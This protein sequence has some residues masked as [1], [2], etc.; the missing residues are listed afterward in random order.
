MGETISGAPATGA[1]ESWLDSWSEGQRLDPELFKEHQDNSPIYPALPG[2]D[3]LFLVALPLELL[4]LG[5][6][7]GVRARVFIPVV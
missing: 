4:S 1:L 6:N 5:W 7:P 3:H 2:G